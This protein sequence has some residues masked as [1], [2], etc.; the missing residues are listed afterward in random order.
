MFVQQ[1]D[2][3]QRRHVAGTDHDG[4][5]LGA[6]VVARP[7]PDLHSCRAVVHGRIHVEEL[8]RRLLPRYDHVHVVA[9]PAQPNDLGSKGD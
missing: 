7:L 3:G 2:R 5:R 9:A 1:R 8:E 4:V 6:A